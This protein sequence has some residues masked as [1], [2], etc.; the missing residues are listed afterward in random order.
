MRQAALPNH[1]ILWSIAML[2][3][4]LLVAFLAAV[5]VEADEFVMTNPTQPTCPQGDLLWSQTV[6]VTDLNPSGIPNVQ[7]RFSRGA[8]FPGVTRFEIPSALI[9]EAVKNGA[10]VQVTIP[11]AVAWDGYTDR[12]TTGEQADERFK[13][14]FLKNGV[15]QYQSPYTGD[16]SGAPND[17]GIITGWLSDE[18]VGPLGG[19]VN[20]PNGAD[21][22]ILVHWSDTLYGTGDIETP[23]SVVPTSVCIQFRTV[24]AVSMASSSATPVEQPWALLLLAGAL[25]AA[26][27]GLL[28]RRRVLN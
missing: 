8:P 22:I 26:T 27:T 20:L 2:G 6:D 10:N 9:P 4:A 21:Q 1:A 3:L 28:L 11:E 7:V 18:W 25:A 5:E 12:G 15:I 13:I 17:D 23:N 24:T 19:T 14:V 16:F